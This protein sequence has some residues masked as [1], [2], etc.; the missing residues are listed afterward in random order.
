[1][2]VTAKGQLNGSYPCSVTNDGTAAG[3]ELCCHTIAQIADFFC[4]VFETGFLHVALA[5]SRN[6][7]AFVPPEGREC[8]PIACLKVQ[9]LTK[10]CLNQWNESG[11]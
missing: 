8:T 3:S 5:E 2:E 1:M 9:I 10:L 11:T 6:P 4:F 7:L